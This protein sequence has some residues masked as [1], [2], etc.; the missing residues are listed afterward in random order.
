MDLFLIMHISTM[1]AN[2]I[3]TLTNKHLD[4]EMIETQESSD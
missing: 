4:S 1:P 3:K 2:R